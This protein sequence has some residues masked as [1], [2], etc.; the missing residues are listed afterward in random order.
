MGPVRDENGQAAVELIGMVPLLVVLALGA[1]QLLAAGKA[2]ELAGHAAEAGAVGM[3]QGEDPREAARG[4]L[5]PSV[6]RRLRVSVDGSRVRVR[7][8]P[9]AVVPGVAEL[10]TAEASAVAGAPR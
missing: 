4:A 6:V 1:A 7:L 5:D 9:V 2:H 8:A 3:L 10:L